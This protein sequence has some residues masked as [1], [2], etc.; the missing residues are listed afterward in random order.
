[1][2]ASP[3]LTTL[4]LHPS[5][6]PLSLG[7]FIAADPTGLTDV[8]GVWVAGNVTDLTAQVVTAAAGGAAA[9]AAINADLIAEDTQR[10]VT[11]YRSARS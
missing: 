10:A 11:G 6:H 1:V 4:G 7:E 8:P 9:A 3:L 2:A 5:P